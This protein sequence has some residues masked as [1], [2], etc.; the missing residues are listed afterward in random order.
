MPKRS[1][2]AMPTGSLSIEETRSDITSL[3]LRFEKNGDVVSQLEVEVKENGK[4]ELLLKGLN[5]DWTK[6]L[7]DT[8][9]SLAYTE[10]TKSNDDD[11]DTA[12][13]GEDKM[14]DTILTTCEGLL[15]DEVMTKIE[16]TPSRDSFQAA[17]EALPR[18]NTPKPPSTVTSSPAPS[19]YG[20]DSFS[21]YIKDT[22]A[23][24]KYSVKLRKDGGLTCDM[25]KAL[26]ETSNKHV[27]KNVFVV[28]AKTPANNVMMLMLSKAKPKA[29]HHIGRLPKGI[30]LA[31]GNGK[32]SYGFNVNALAVG[33]T[34]EEMDM[35]RIVREAV[36]LYYMA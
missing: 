3:V 27:K 25:T 19:E 32:A 22:I 5:F 14:L 29:A 33:Y 15:A 11:L 36:I 18:I 9:V 35:L 30:E 21:Q 6:P 20:D 17:L 4:V 24:R 34:N 10:V 31:I 1:T 26:G 8:N 23:G 12:H 16:G 28:K 13:E 7:I 2:P